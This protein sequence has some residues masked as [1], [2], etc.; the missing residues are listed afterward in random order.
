MKEAMFDFNFGFFFTILLAIMF[1]MLGYLVFYGSGIELEKSGIK[2]SA[3]IVKLYTSNLGEWATPIITI[4]AFTAMFSTTLTV[5]A[6]YPRSLS[7]G[8]TDL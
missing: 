3:Q 7:V 5:I 1:L 2:F 6:A 4:A 8:L